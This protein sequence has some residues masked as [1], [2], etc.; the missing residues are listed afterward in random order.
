MISTFVVVFRETLEAALIISIVMAASRGIAGRMRWVA[1]GVAAGIIGA[2]LLALGADFISGLFNGTGSDLFSAV[3]LLLAAGMLGG[4]Q[5]WMGTHGAEL[6]TQS[7]AVGDGVRDR[8]RPLSALAVVAAI[9]VLREGSET[10]LF[11]Y[12]ISIDASSGSRAMLAGGLFGVAAAVLLGGVLYFGLLRIPLKYVF[13][14][15]GVI[16][17]LIAAGLAAQAGAYLVQSGLLPALGYD[18]W[19]TSVLLPQHEPLGTV[20]HVL[21]GYVARPQGIQIVFYA[22]TVALIVAISAFVRRRKASAA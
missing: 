14:V 7:R 5:I 17:I 2:G 11:L 4:H 16:L 1:G 8:S 9:A 10:V 13:K 15:T 21:V 22:A 18:I 20:L 3:V 6:A 12:G 19:D